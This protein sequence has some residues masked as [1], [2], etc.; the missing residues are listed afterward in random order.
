MSLEYKVVVVTGASTGFGRATAVELARRGATVVLAARSND[1]LQEAAQEC[2]AVGGRAVALPTDVSQ[3]DEVARLVSEVTSRLGGFDVWINNAGVGAI[4]PF[5]EVPL[6]T[7]EQVIKTN[8]LG[9]LYGSHH[10]LAHFRKRGQGILIN[11]ASIVGKIPTPYYAS[12]VA[13]KFGVVGMSDALRQE[14][15]ERDLE[16][17]RVC[18][19]MPMAHATEFF[20]HAANY[21]G[22]ESEPI[23]PTYDPQVTVD[24]IVK[25]VTDPEDE[26]ITGRQGPMFEVMHRLMPKAIERVMAKNTEHTQFDKAD[27]A[28][29]TAGAVHRASEDVS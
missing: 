10:A 24:A 28:P 1:L 7:H 4:G 2:D 17:I 20:E 11:V 15:K 25:L 14:L 23:P 5:D 29:V 26:V 3:P 16:H 9:V 21:T 8:L 18:T 19:V 12:Y 27:P 13:S 22:R 6:E